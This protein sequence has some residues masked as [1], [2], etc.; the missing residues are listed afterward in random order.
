LSG[1]N[2][3][4][5]ATAV[6]E[7]T[8]RAGAGNTFSPASAHSVAAGATLDLAGFSQ[9][10]AGLANAGTVS[11]IGAT[12]GTTLTVNGP[13]VG[14]NGLLRLGTFLGDSASASDRVILS[15]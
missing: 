4:G 13:Y 14:N 10:I 11:L 6:T 3:Y 5:G 7:G 15:G 12:P 8:L 1:A 2:S 9:S